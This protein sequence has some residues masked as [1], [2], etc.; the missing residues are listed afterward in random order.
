MPLD[1]MEPPGSH[2]CSGAWHP[3][4]E[5]E[6]C[7]TSTAPAGYTWTLS[8]KVTRVARPGS[9]VYDGPPSGGLRWSTRVT[10]TMTGDHTASP[11][12]GALRQE[13]HVVSRGGVLR[14]PLATD[15]F[16]HPCTIGMI[17]AHKARLPRVRSAAT[18]RTMRSHAWWRR[19][20]RQRWDVV[21][22]PGPG[23]SPVGRYVR[24]V[25]GE[26]RR[27]SLSRSWGTR[28]KSVQEALGCVC[29]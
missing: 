3:T 20:V 14:H 17:R 6:P 21:P 7:V 5:G 15:R 18:P 4:C 25:L 8:T 9:G 29:S 27:P 28:T 24:T 23:V 22:R 19:N 2:P 26:T 13:S 16:H 1:A 12:A 10:S 11:D